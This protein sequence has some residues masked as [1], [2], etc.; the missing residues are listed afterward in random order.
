MNDRTNMTI[1]ISQPSHDELFEEMSAVEPTYHPDPE[2]DRDFMGNFPPLM[3]QG[4]WRTIA[5]RDGLN[6]TL[7]SLQLRDRVRSSQPEVPEDY[8]EFHLHLSGI[9]ENDGDLLRSGEYCIYGS[10]L[11]PKA[12]FDLSEQQPFWEV[13]IHMRADLLKSFIGDSNGEIPTALQPWTRS[14]EQ[15]RY[16]CFRTATPAMQLATRQILKCGFQGI[17]KRLFL[18]GKS[19]ELL[20]L[21]AA[22]E[23][24]RNGGSRTYLQSD[25]IDRIHHAKDIL[26]Q[27]LDNPP[28][29]GELARLVGLNEYSLKQ[30]FRQVF[31]TTV[32]GYLHDYRM[33][34]ARQALEM[35]DWK[36]G[37]VARMVGYTNLPAF[38][39]AFSKRFNIN[40]RDCLQKKS[41]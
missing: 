5:L 30:G 23:I 3:G 36:V 24:D 28:H 12:E 18:E 9:H 29:L 37:E 33:K 20:G 22:A 2:D 39:R 38:S 34:Q 35:G 13:Q 40:P 25:A 16:A 10:G 32:F 15:P 14:L 41:V 8:L 21:F 6:L 17:A 7:G 11:M 31:N 1:F 19:L 4:T 26:H 27:R